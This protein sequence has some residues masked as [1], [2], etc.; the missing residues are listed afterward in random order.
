LAPELGFLYHRIEDLARFACTFP[1][2]Q[3]EST[4]IARLQAWAPSNFISCLTSMP[5]AEQLQILDG[6]PAAVD[7]PRRP[8]AFY[9]FLLYQLDKE[10]TSDNGSRLMDPLGGVDFSSINEFISGSGAP[11][12]TSTRSLSVDLSYEPFVNGV[13]DGEKKDVAFCNVLQHTLC[14]ETR[15]M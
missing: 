3:G 14:R 2:T 1:V 6:S 4:G 11:S 13:K 10:L 8:E 5:E 15:N 7:M 12:I 9:R